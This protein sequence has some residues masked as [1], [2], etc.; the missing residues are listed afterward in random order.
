MK[1]LVTGSEGYTG[2][3]VVPALIDH[4]HEVVGLDAGFFRDGCIGDSGRPFVQKDIRHLTAADL[5]G[6][7]AVVHL[8]E[9]SNEAL[10][11]INHRLTLEINFE[12]SVT[13][14]ELCKTAGV[15]RF[16]YP[17]SCCVYGT[18][19]SG[20]VDESSP[21]QP[22]TTY[23]RCKAMV[24]RKLTAIADD[25][26]SPTILRHGSCFGPARQMRFDLFVNQLAG[27]AWITRELTIVT[28]EKGWPPLVSVGDFAAAIA[29]VVE[30]PRQNVHNEILNVTDHSQT[31]RSSEI[32]EIVRTVFPSCSLHFIGPRGN[33]GCLQVHSEK[34]EARL[35]NFRHR[36]NLRT[37][38]LS[39]RDLFERIDLSR[40]LFEFRGFARMEQIK[41]LLQ[42]QQLDRRLYWQSNPHWSG[43]HLPPERLLQEIARRFLSRSPLPIESPHA[44][45]QHQ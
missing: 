1:I 30:A 44:V 2:C 3:C 29:S 11:E 34:I 19:A 8:A 12:A 31:Y 40:E 28:P 20:T 24:E 25:N 17:S 13:L 35:P 18:E 33:A 37:G 15:A 6:F 42:T 16:V 4:G 26:F 7:D 41:Y 43:A 23:A 32:A 39:L 10:A 38:M 36:Q 14:A 22:N 21:I 27:Q 45:P 5:R 9:L